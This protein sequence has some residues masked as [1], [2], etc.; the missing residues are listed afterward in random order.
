MG[1][2]RHIYLQKQSNINLMTDPEFPSLRNLLDSLYRK[3]HSAGI[4]TSAKKTEVPNED[5]EKFWAS[6]VLNPDTPQGLLNCIFFLNG[7][8]FYFRGG[9]EHHELPIPILHT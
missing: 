5:W 2:Q 6:G 9:S 1:I 3:L 7:K 4:G 8:G